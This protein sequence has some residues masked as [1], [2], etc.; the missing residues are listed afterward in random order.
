MIR[1]KLIPKVAFAIALTGAIGAGS[2]SVAS[3]KCKP[4]PNAICPEIYSPVI[5]SNGHVYSNQCFADAACATG[6]VPY[7]Q[8]Q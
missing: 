7:N 8:V 5:C 6:C 2:V 3:A 4:N 1:A